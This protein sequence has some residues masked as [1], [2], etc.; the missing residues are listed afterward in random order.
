MLLCE[1]R[2]GNNGKVTCL[3]NSPA[4]LFLSPSSHSQTQRCREGRS[5]RG[6]EYGRPCATRGRGIN[7]FIDH[8]LWKIPE[9][10]LQ[11]CFLLFGFFF[12]TH[13]SN[14]TLQGRT[15]EKHKG[16]SANLLND[17][18]PKVEEGREQEDQARRRSGT[19][20]EKG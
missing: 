14:E 8:E 20:G 17:R 11:D 12:L 9:T 19:R 7:W 15:E 2:E 4:S 13:T 1:W 10:G 6:E 5:A 3:N 18:S 16:S